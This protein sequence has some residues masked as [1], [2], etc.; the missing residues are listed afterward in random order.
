MA[1]SA[2]PA[3]L[4]ILKTWLVDTGPLVAYLDAKDPAHRDVATCLEGFTGQLATTSAVVTETM[5]MVDA[6]RAGPR[7]FA[8]FVRASAMAVY[9]LGRPP[10]LHQVVSLMEKYDDT[11]MDYADGTL[12]LLAEALNVHEV[13]TLDRRGFS[14]YRTRRNRNLR[15]VLDVS[16][17]P[18]RWR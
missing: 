17:S 8:D 16:R 2:S 14:T 9:D 12:V 15:L 6:S 13:V 5:H 4:E 11:P 18:E 10:E 3:E 1:S 7:L